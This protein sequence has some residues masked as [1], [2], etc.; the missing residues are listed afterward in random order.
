VQAGDALDFW[1]VLAAEPGHRLKLVAEM[2]VPGE[3]VLEVLLTECVDGTTEVRQCARFRPRGLF[4]LLYWYSVLPLHNLV[5]VGMLRG[6]ARA[7]GGRILAG[8]EPLP[9]P[10]RGA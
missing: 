8:P 1:R 2:K 10:K 9:R 7:A 4:G 6:I 3:A 5:F